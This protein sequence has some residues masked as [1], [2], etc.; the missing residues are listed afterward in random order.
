[1]K[2]SKD[3]FYTIIY[4]PYGMHNIFRNNRR[5]PYLLSTFIYIGISIILVEF[6]TNLFIQ[7][8][9]ESEKEEIRY[10][11][12]LIRSRI[13]ANIYRDAYLAE[14]ISTLVTMAPD[15][16]VKNW[17]EIAERLFA[18]A[19][20]VR[21]VALSP[22]DIITQVYPLK[23][24]EQAIGLDLRTLPDQYHTI[25]KARR[26]QN[27]FLSE[28]T[29]LVQGGKGIIARYPIFSDFPYKQQYWGG[30]SVVLDYEKML[31]Q[32]GAFSVQGA[33]LAIGSSEYGKKEHTLIMGDAKTFDNSDISFPIHLPSGSWK[34]YARYTDM[35]SI[36]YRL[37]IILRLSGY[38][39]LLAIY[40]L[41]YLLHRNYQ[42]VRDLSFQDELT[43]LPNRRYMLD[44][45]DKLMVQAVNSEHPPCFALLSIDLNK[46]KDVNDTY[47]HLAGDDLLK[48]VAHIFVKNLRASDVVSRFGGDEFVIL[49]YRISTTE[50][51][52][53]VIRQIHKAIDETV[54]I[55]DGHEIYP[56]VSIGYALY[57]KEQN[58]DIDELL[59]IADQNMY[60]E[61]GSA[62]R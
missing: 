13:E 56:A 38:L 15:F 29:D 55:W 35:Y 39:M 26:Y 42:N 53:N 51:V 6:V 8:Q 16:A 33:D 24:N 45:L 43:A 59:A 61:K 58:F 23:G 50:E 30:V 41:I 3:D 20:Y 4:S 19:Y 40:V 25:L 7:N 11:I 18:R 1:M 47:G 54:L 60:R 52:E 21:N 14:S 37:P 36:D 22:N 9:V 17:A 32:S 5:W 57:S 12:A 62:N 31:Q 10:Q 49:L 34:I 44:L 27:V 46:F 2:V 48:H 28:P